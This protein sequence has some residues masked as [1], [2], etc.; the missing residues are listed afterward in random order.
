[1]HRTSSTVAFSFALNCVMLSSQSCSTA[2]MRLPKGQ[3]GSREKDEKLEGSREIGENLEGR[4]EIEICYLGA[5]SRLKEG[6]MQ[7]A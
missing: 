3:S 2:I 1:M 7:G 4:R 6:K 5:R